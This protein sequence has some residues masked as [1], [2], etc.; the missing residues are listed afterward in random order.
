MVILGGLAIVIFYL[1]HF[2]H[3]DTTHATII[4]LRV[5]NINSREFPEINIEDKNL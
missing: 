3:C 2:Q 5:T 4:Y 1:L